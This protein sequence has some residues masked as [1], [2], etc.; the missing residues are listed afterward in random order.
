VKSL[1]VVTRIAIKLVAQHGDKIF[2][3]RPP[4]GSRPSRWSHRRVAKFVSARY[5]PPL[6]DRKSVLADAREDQ[7][8]MLASRLVVG[9]LSSVSASA[10]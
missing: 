2:W 9:Q 4:A 8:I 10:I 5:A 6:P 1:I 3:D 7:R